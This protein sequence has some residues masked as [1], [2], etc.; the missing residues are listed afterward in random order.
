MPMADRYV[1]EEFDPKT[2]EEEPFRAR[3]ELVVT[4]AQE[5]EPESP[6]EPFEKHRKYMIDRPSFQR[7]KH[8]T[9]W[10]G[11]RRHAL[12]EGYLGLDYLDTN[13]HLSWIGIGVLPE[14][15]RQGIATALLG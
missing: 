14:A 6:V 2:A 3:W 10:D 5:A 13:R 9:A 15:R 8:W 11:E 12:A 7:P 4:L 1:I